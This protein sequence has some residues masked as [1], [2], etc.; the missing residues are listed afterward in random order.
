MSDLFNIRSFVGNQVDKLTSPKNILVDKFRQTV[1][2][3][4]LPFS[5]GSSTTTTNNNHDRVDE[6]TA[7][8]SLCTMRPSE[9]SSNSSVSS[10]EHII[11]HLPIS[12]QS[13]SRSNQSTPPNSKTISNIL[14]SSSPKLLSNFKT[15]TDHFT[16]R[17]SILRRHVSES[18]QIDETGIKDNE[19]KSLSQPIYHNNPPV[20]ANFSLEN[21]HDTNRLT[22]VTTKFIGRSRS[23]IRQSTDTTCTFPIRNPMRRME[24]IET[25]EI[26][27]LNGVKSIR[28]LNDNLGKLQPD[29][30][31]KQ[32]SQ[33]DPT[34]GC[35]KITF[36]VFYN[37]Q[38][39]S[40]I[41]TVL[42]IENLPYRDVNSKILPDPFIKIVLLPDRRKKFQTKVHKRTQSIEI[43]E[44]FQFQISY[45]ELRRRILLLS[46]YDFGRSTKRKLIGTVKIDDV[47]IMPEIA[48][49]DV[50]CVRSIVPGTESDP[51]LGE[52]TVSLCYLPNAKRVTVTLVKA[53][54]LKPM[55]IT[56]KSDPYVKVIL[57]IN[58]KKIRKKKTSVQSNTLNPTYNESLEF[59]IAVESLE[60]TDLIFKV[61]DYDRVGA[62]E[63][64][65]CVGIG[66]HFDG[67]NYD[68]WYQMIEH[69]RVPITESYNL[70][71]TIPI[72]PCSSPRMPHKTLTSNNI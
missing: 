42:S 63:L 36:T 56:G 2:N 40:L 46:V 45:E 29:L 65:G 24:S 39:T 26:P 19:D 41:V 60:D 44:S 18:N 9:S 17:Q 67:I 55:D 30:Y 1:D 21:N 13:V 20:E 49:N 31:M 58:G 15:L 14:P 48:S 12:R 43:N 33:S 47:S 53:S 52:L 66:V 6:L 38:I 10:N 25:V 37:Q 28:Y 5:T 32:T 70:R 54:A 64:I 3:I 4:K 35:G 34:Y 11:S 69:P 27:G 50:T 22:D 61:I 57:L 51:D 7:Q 68:H 59:D 71:E 16:R 23:L 62:N 8:E 72:I